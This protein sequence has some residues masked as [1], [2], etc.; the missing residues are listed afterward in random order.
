MKIMTLMMSKKKNLDITQQPQKKKRGCGRKE[1]IPKQSKQRVFDKRQEE[2]LRSNLIKWLKRTNMPVV[3]LS[4][5]SDLT[6]N[7]IGLKKFYEH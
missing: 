6:V 1:Y 3:A 4:M 2:Q 7:Y 5:S